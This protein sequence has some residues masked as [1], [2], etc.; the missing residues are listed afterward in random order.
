MQREGYDAVVINCF[1]DPGLHASREAASILVLGIGETSILTALQ[2]GLRI[3]IISTGKNASSL[4]YKKALE[5]GLTSRIVYT[6]GI[7]LK[8]LDMRRDVEKLKKLVVEEARK[9]VEN[10]G[11]EVLVLGCGGFIGLAKEVEAE[12][13]IPV[14]DPTLTTF[15]I[16][17]AL[18][19]LGLKHGKAGLYNPPQHKIEEWKI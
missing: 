18:A 17:E 13:G 3:A 15:K 2:L 1:D 19:V 4:Y 7:E 6:S 14:V 5:M 8:V 10:Y 11:V 9:A 12:I 16:A